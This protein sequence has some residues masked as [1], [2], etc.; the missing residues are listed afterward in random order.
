MKGLDDTRHTTFCSVDAEL[1]DSLESAISFVAEHGGGVVYTDL[2]D[3]LLAHMICLPE[4]VRLEKSRDG[5]KPG[6]GKGA[7]GPRQ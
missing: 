3:S 2:A 4:N 6:R 5:K 7:R 1:F